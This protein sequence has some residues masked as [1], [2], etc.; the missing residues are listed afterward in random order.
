MRHA[1]APTLLLL[2]ASVAA[3]AADAA[4]EALDRAVAG[5]PPAGPAAVPPGHAAPGLRLIDLSLAVAG[6]A[7]ASTASDHE[8]EG[9]QAGG[10]DPGR[11][12]FSLQTAELSLSGA[13][14]PYFTAQAHIAASPEHGVELEEAHITTTALPYALEARAGYQ[15]IE[16]GRVNPSHMHGWTWIDQPVIA[17]RLLGG[18]GSRAAGARLAWLAPVGWYS[19]LSVGAYNSDDGSLASFRGEAGGHDHED[20]GDEPERSL[21]GRLRAEE[22]ETGSMADLL[23][24]ARWEN[25]GD[26]G[27]AEV[28]LGLSWL[29]G[30]N[31]TGA[32]MRSDLYGADLVIGA[33]PASG[34]FRSIKAVVEAMYRRAG[35]PESAEAGEDGAHG[36]GDDFTAPAATLVD[37]GL[38]AQVELGLS[39][40]WSVGLRG[41]YAAAS[42]DSVGHEGMIDPDADALRD[43]R[44]RVSPLISYRPSE[45]SR[46]R[47]QYDYDRAEHLADGEAH[48]LWLGLDV[49]IGAHPAH[50]F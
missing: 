9:L 24:L 18:D 16:F 14:D 10:H 20:H 19:Q 22:L 36:T 31:A 39:E 17:S 3:V 11:R 40:R 42:G 6:A 25:A 49:L 50:G 47:L 32:G 29:G 38:Y 26:L 46:L 8:L 43:T 48:S 13:V 27:G 2:S 35:V 12:G 5:L 28:K 34:P 7:G 1:L 33:K 30:A 21:G 23:W 45:F 37:W 44:V 4:A 41:E 15:L